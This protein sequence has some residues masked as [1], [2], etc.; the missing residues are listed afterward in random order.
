MK[1]GVRGVWN[2]SIWTCACAAAALPVPERMVERW[3]SFGLY[4]HLQHVVTTCSNRF[5]FALLDVALLAVP[6]VWIGAAMR[7]VWTSR[8]K[9]RTLAQWALRTATAGAVG[10]LLFLLMWGLNYRRVPLEQKLRYDPT[11]VTA[12]AA[13]EL[14]GLTVGRL[15]ALFDAAHRAVP[16]DTG[17]D[18]ELTVAFE[19]A[20]H[21]LGVSATTVPARPKRSLLDFYFRSA[22]VAGMT[23]PYFLETLAESDLLDVERPFVIAHEWTHLAGFA[24][25]GEANF[26]GW[27]TCLRADPPSQYSGW[28]FLFGELMNS[29][30][31]ADRPVLIAQLRSGPRSDLRAI[32]ARLAHDVKPE[33]S[34]AG[35][36]V[37]DGYLK[38]NRVE[39]GAASYAQVVRL[40]LGTRVGL[41]DDE[42]ASPVR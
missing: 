25:E 23:D 3:Y 16:N 10:Y 42:A 24:D 15:N 30:A 11:G 12:A 33:V 17:R 9:A 26:G 38:A 32:A 2:L 6:V 39:L 28:L 41:S 37:Y 27:L 36:R 29:V 8:R 19:R 34:E 5:P 21:E 18:R 35:W 22:G 14:A 31:R 1:L 4:P 40:L 7:D 13:R 20:M